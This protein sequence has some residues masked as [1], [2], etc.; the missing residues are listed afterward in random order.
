MARTTDLQGK[1]YNIN[2]TLTASVISDFDN[3]IVEAYTFKNKPVLFSLVEKEK[4]Y[5][6][7]AVSETE[8]K[9]KLLSVETRKMK[10]DLFIKIEGYKDDNV[11]LLEDNGVG[12]IDTTI[13]IID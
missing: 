4:H 12:R 13:T 7:I 11:Y 9:V 10:G 8:F 6:I 2:C 1:T 3:I 5:P